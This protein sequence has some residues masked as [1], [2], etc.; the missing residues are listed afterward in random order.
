MIV[1]TLKDVTQVLMKQPKMY[2]MS[3]EITYNKYWVKTSADD[4][5]GFFLETKLYYNVGLNKNANRF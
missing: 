1:I 2:R 3:N 5:A 4:K